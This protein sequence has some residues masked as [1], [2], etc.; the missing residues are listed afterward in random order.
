LDGILIFLFFLQYGNYNETLFKANMPE[1]PNPLCLN[2][3]QPTK[4]NSLMD[5]F[6]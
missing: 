3:V 4:S 2:T 6:F 5:Q 1:G